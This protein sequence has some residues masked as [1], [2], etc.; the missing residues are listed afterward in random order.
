MGVSLAPKSK[1]SQ[2]DSTSNKIKH[3]LGLSGLGYGKIDPIHK[4]SITK[5]AITD[6]AG[7]SHIS[8]DNFNSEDGQQ[9]LNPIINNDFTNQKSQLEKELG[10]QV[11]ITAAFDGERRRLRSEY[12]KEAEDRRE[13]AKNLPDGDPNKLRLEAEAQ[14]IE[15]NIRLFDGLASAL[16]TP[17]TGGAVG[18]VARAV[19]PHMAY[20]IGQYFKNNDYKNTQDN[21]NRPGEQSLQHLMAHA[22]LG[23]ATSYATGN[24][25]TT[26]A[27][28]AVSSEA[29]APTLSKFLFGKDSKELTQDEKDTITNIITLAT[30]STAYTITDGDVANSVSAAEVGRVAVENNNWGGETWAYAVAGGKE[31][32]QSQ[33]SLGVY[34]ANQGGDIQNCINNLQYTQNQFN[35]N[36]N[37]ATKIADVHNYYNDMTIVSLSGGMAGYTAIVNNKSGEVWVSEFQ[38]I[39]ISLT[40]KDVKNLEQALKVNPSGKISKS[41]GFG[42]SINF[43]SIKGGKKDAAAINKAIEGTS[44]GI[45]ACNGLCVGGIR[46][47]GRDGKTIYTYGVG[48]TQFGLNGGKMKKT[49]IVLTKEAINKLLDIE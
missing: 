23:A 1:S 43:G 6:Q 38:E 21:Q 12:A 40:P 41:V 30:A 8:T 49:N 29:A 10:G 33:A 2:Q 19:S 26:G 47:A 27:L 20:Q 37:L 32:A 11:T 24:D 31:Y 18:D 4:T 22:I 13:E 34:C 42:A 25:I 45:Q 28:S 39:G 44:L 9:A 48:T 35:L 16:Y 15:R 5:S 36:K 7:L 17:N 3:Q 14:K 46:T